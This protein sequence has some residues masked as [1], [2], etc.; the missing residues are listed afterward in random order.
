M[1]KAMDERRRRHERRQRLDAA[2]LCIDCGDQPRTENLDGSQSVRCVVC[3]QASDRSKTRTRTKPR[4]AAATEWDIE[5]DFG[6]LDTPRFKQYAASV[7]STIR[8]LTTPVRDDSGKVVGQR[9][10]TIAEQHRQMAGGFAERM[11]ADAL[12]YLM[13]DGAIIERQCGAMQRYQVAEVRPRAKRHWNNTP[14]A[15][16]KVTP[17]P[18]PS[19]FEDTKHRVTA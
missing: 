4:P 6:C 15:G 7:L 16:P 11:H 13:A 2:G 17:R 14:I 1:N 3:K 10:S 8:R 19:A 12:E 18:D 5:E 9:G